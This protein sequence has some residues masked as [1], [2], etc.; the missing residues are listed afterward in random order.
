[1]SRVV[2]AVAR[3]TKAEWLAT[4]GLIDAANVSVSAIQPSDENST[5]K[6]STGSNDKLTV[7]DTIKQKPAQI[8]AT[9]PTVE[10]LG[11]ADDVASTEPNDA[12]NVPVGAERRKLD[13]MISPPTSASD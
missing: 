1:V 6:Y 8:I 4:A 7:D 11:E 13:R 3:G 12:K 5:V 2:G 10:K 9:E